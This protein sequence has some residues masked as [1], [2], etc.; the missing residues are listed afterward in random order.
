MDSVNRLGPE[1]ILLAVAGLIVLADVVFI[2]AGER[3]R[4]AKRLGLL[5]LA[6]AGAAGSI[7]GRR[8]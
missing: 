8:R 7:A 2:A 5:A 1:L 6:L 3:S 4:Q